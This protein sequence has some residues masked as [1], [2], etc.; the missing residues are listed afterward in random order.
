MKKQTTLILLL[1]CLIIVACQDTRKPADLSQNK[2]LKT[3]KRIFSPS[4]SKYIEIFKNGSLKGQ[5]ITQVYIHS[6]NGAEEIYST[7]GIDS[8]IQVSWI[9]ETHVELSTS[10]SDFI[11]K[12]EVTHLFKENIE[13]AYQEL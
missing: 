13:V 4:K 12:E 7:P 9:D 11:I 1:T 8:T 3:S 2:A 10:D 5:P 6:A